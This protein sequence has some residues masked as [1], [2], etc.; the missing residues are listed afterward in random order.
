MPFEPTHTIFGRISCFKEITHCVRAFFPLTIRPAIISNVA[1]PAH[2][3]R[4]YY[5]CANLWTNGASA[6]VGPI[7]ISIIFFTLLHHYVRLV[8]KNANN[9]AHKASPII[10]FIRRDASFHFLLFEMSAL[11]SSNLPTQPFNLEAGNAPLFGKIVA[12]KL[13][14]EGAPSGCAR[15][16]LPCQNSFNTIFGVCFHF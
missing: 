8:A 9:F 5:S 7:W 12:I 16:T 13:R 4:K 2:K 14:S 15:N 10:H 3:Q 1:R 11:Y 6:G